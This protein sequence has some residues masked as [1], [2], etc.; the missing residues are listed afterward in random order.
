MQKWVANL[1]FVCGRR[2]TLYR[3]NVDKVD[4]K[5]VAWLVGVG[6]KASYGEFN[7]V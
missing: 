3:Q 5:P 1:T 7:E 2:S 6:L 4:I